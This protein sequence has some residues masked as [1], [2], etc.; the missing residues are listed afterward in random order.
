MVKS[1]RMY[2]A[3]GYLK[4]I[5]GK[6]VQSKERSEIELIEKTVGDELWNYPLTEID[7][8]V[9]NNINVVLV[10]CL[11]WR[12]DDA[13]DYDIVYRWCEVPEDFKG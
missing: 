3:V 10:A 12:G 11:E 5:T 9:E 7:H 8:I 4:E 2:T 13:S 6:W 1:E